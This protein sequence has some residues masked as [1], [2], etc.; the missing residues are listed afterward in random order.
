MSGPASPLTPLEILT[1]YAAGTLGTR[2]TIERLGLQDYADLV[3]ALA[4]AD[5]PL[6][7]PAAS[8]ARTTHL[9]Q[10]SAILQPRLRR[11]LYRQE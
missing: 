6:P 4:Q 5:L 7:R 8:L 3:I 9:A 10:A 11:H 2:N 1:A